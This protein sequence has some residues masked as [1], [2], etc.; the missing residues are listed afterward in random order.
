M[1]N[2]MS[3]CLCGFKRHPWLK[4]G[5]L[6]LML[7]LGGAVYLSQPHGYRNLERL[8]NL[9][10][11]CT[12]PSAS[13]ADV[14][15]CLRRSGIEFSALPKA[16]EDEPVYFDGRVRITAHKGDTPMTASTHSGAT[17]PFP[18]G[19]ADASCWYSAQTKGCE[20]V[21]SR[22]FGRACSAAVVISQL[23]QRHLL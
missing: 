15:D 12:S 7:V 13:M 6:V 4:G 9:A 5:L 23:H 11:R 22:D 10:N 14:G 16:E 1:T 18:C 19:R 17:G 8:E 21:R 20:I 2:S 3:A